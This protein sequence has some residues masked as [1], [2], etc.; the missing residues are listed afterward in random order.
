M[1]DN[2]FLDTNLIVYLYSI[3]ESEKKLKVQ[4]IISH[5]N[6]FISTQV[7]NE[8]SNV[9]FKKFRLSNDKVRNA[10]NEVIPMLILLNISVEDIFEAISLK[11]NYKYSYYDSLIIAT[12]LRNNCSI[13]FTE[14]MHTNQIVENNLK[15]INPFI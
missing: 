1:K 12:A 10:L 2:V 4:S 3:D 7:V 11:G 15:I 8:F 5:N 9:L 6:C 13:L 14:D